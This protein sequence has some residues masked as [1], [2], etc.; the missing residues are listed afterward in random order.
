V[1]HNIKNH[2]KNFS[3]ENKNV[4]ELQSNPMHGQF[5]QDLERLSIDKSPQCGHVAQT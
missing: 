3:T 1:A 5:Y 4:E 2:L